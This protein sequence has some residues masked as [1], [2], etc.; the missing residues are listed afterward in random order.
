MS[1]EKEDDEKNG[2][3]HSNKTTTK[4]KK[5]LVPVAKKESKTDA[6]SKDSK[7]NIGAKANI[8]EVRANWA[9]P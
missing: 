6:D 7:H 8:K 2:A 1:H 4:K 9:C 5:K 3:E